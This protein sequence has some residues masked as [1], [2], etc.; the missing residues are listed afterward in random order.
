M[1]TIPLIKNFYLEVGFHKHWYKPFAISFAIILALLFYEKNLIQ[2]G[3]LFLF[4]GVTGLFLE[5]NRRFYKRK[6]I[7]NLEQK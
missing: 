2:R 3:N 4:L 7:T 6:Y 1:I 5:I